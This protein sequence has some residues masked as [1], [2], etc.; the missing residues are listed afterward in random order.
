MAYST[1]RVNKKPCKSC[2]RIDYIFSRGRC[3][4]CAKVESFYAK[5]EKIV[6]EDGLSD[7]IA[8]LDA[9]VS[10]W[11][12][13]NAV[14]EFGLVHCFTCPTRLPPAQLDAGHYVSRNCMHLR[15]DAARNIRPQCQSCNRSKYGKAAQFGINLELEYPGLTDILLEESTIIVKPTRDDLRI[16]ISDYTQ[17]IKLLSK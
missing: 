11:V 13:H 8:D 2:G 17:R 6:K 3:Q 12:R 4:Q 15:F 16:L 14:D 10:R 1:I 7:L 9:L 5:E